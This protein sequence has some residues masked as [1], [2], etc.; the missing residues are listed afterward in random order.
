[1]NLAAFHTGLLPYLVAE[2]GEGAKQR[3]NTGEADCL[4]VWSRPAVEPGV[5]YSTSVCAVMSWKSG[6]KLYLSGTC[7]LRYSIHQALS[8]HCL[9]LSNLPDGECYHL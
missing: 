6:D 9:K 3:G 1:M 7:G 5:S 8:V 4:S 2:G